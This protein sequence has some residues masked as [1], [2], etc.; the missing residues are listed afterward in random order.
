MIVPIFEFE[1]FGAKIFLRLSGHLFVQFSTCA[2]N[3]GWNIALK[4]DKKAYFA[5]LIAYHAEIKEP[6]DHVTPFKAFE[7]G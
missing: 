4:L 6:T 2:L 3:K 5:F 1:I 7:L